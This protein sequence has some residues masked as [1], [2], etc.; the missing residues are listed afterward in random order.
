QRRIVVLAGVHED[1]LHGP[2]ARL[3]VVGR[4]RVH[5]RRDLHEVG[6]GA[7][8]RK[9]L[10]QW[11]SAPRRPRTDFRMP[12]ALA[13]VPVVGICCHGSSGSFSTA[14]TASGAVAVSYPSRRARST[15][16]SML[17]M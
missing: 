16:R 5:E 3:L 17:G 15:N 9:Q 6:A 12:A 7:D 11:L 13:I 8:D 10:H 1:V 2:R 4:D 14:S